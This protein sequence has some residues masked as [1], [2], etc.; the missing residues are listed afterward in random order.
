M[1]I[2]WVPA[3][4]IRPNKCAFIP[5]IGSHHPKGFFDLVRRSWLSTGTR[6]AR[7][8]RRSRWRR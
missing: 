8:L 5:F 7:L 1:S 3:A 4:V 2:R 6:T